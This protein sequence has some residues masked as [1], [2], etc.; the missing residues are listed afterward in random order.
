MQHHLSLDPTCCQS[1]KKL[2]SVALRLSFHKR[3][4]GCTQPIISLYSNILVTYDDSGVL[5]VKGSVLPS[6][7]EVQRHDSNVRQR[8]STCSDIQ[9]SI[10]RNPHY[11]VTM[12][13]IS[14]IGSPYGLRRPRFLCSHIQD[15]RAAVSQR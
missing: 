6:P 5:S 2:S 13:A 12:P 14:Q 9:S 8:W 1:P 7:L 15:Q 11:S 3:R 4:L 10:Q